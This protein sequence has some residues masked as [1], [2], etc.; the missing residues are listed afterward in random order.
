MR[1]G[2]LNMHNEYRFGITGVT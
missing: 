1:T 2:L